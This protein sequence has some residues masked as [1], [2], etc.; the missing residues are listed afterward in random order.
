MVVQQVVTKKYVTVYAK[1]AMGPLTVGMQEA[2]QNGANGAEDN[3]ADFWAVA[4]TAGDLSVSYSESQL[5]KPQ[6]C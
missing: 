3:E 6:Y 4:Y 1:F 2:Y 5:N